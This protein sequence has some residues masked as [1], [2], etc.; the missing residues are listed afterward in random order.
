MKRTLRPS[1]RALIETTT[2]F[3]SIFMISINDFDISAIPL[4]MV[5]ALIIFTNIKILEKF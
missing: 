4:I 3:L 2:I 5:I 1:I